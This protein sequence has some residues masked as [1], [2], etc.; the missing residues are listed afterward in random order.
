MPLIFILPKSVFDL[1]GHYNP[2]VITV[3][4]CEQDPIT[5]E[6]IDKYITTYC[7][8]AKVSSDKFCSCLINVL[9]PFQ[10]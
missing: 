5:V 1:K 8:T 3:S 2:K 9:N 4:E 7:L 6:T 10:I